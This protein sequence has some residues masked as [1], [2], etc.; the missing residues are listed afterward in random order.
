MLVSNPVGY[1]MID[2]KNNMTM[3]YY[4]KDHEG[5]VRVVADQSGKVE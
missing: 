3:H 4:L 2:K 1:A 5:N